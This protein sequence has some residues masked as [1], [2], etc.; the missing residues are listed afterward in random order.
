[1]LKRLRKPFVRVLS[2]SASAHRV[3]TRQVEEKKLQPRYATLHDF[4]KT[5]FLKVR[6]PRPVV[7]HGHFDFSVVTKRPSTDRFS[8]A[9]SAPALHC[10]A[11]AV[12]AHL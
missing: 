10:V 12:L 4:G 7:A 6:G 8:P 3:R 5:R 9:R 1:M 11:V 2:P